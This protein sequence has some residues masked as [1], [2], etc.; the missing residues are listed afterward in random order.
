MA[1]LFA[2]MLFVGFWLLSALQLWKKIIGVALLGNAVNF[3]L[4]LSGFWPRT[5]STDVYVL[6]S[7]PAFLSLGDSEFFSDPV[8]QAL[9]LTAIV[10]GFAVLALLLFYY[11]YQVLRKKDQL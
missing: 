5:K 7:R 11:V 2:I 3:Y 8:S 9:V 4:V 10:I 6:V 1:A